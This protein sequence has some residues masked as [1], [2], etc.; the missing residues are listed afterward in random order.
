MIESTAI[1]TLTEVEEALDRVHRAGRDLRPL[2]TRA[3]KELRADQKKHATEQRGPD[4][5]WAPLKPA[6]VDKRRQR[7]GRQGKRRRRALKARTVKPLGKLPRAFKIEIRPLSIRAASRVPWSGAHQSPSGSTS[8][9][10]HA[11]V[12]SRPFLWASEQLL[13]YVARAT[14]EYLADAWEGRR[15]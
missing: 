6:T 4:G 10:N 11:R 14:V 3:K 15:L 2:F 7:P 13:S 12:E 1:V 9:G 5:A 8:V